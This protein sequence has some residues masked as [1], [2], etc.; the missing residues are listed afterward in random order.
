MESRA[1]R[2]WG[3][4]WVGLCVALAVHVLD[5]AMTDFLSIWNPLVESLRDRSPWLPLP[6][7]EFGAWIGGLISGVVVLF[8]LSP[9]VF[10]GARWMRPFSYL[11]AVVMLA[12]GIGHIAGSLY[13]GRPAPGVYSSPLLL[14]AA[15]FLLL[16]TG[17]HRESTRGDG[18]P[19]ARM[20]DEAA[21]A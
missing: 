10:A 15:G 20:P 5:E 7:F 16:A 13:L 1:R 6:T 2:R 4:A 12:N 3:L 8:L 11:F 19:G 21:G 14:A 9:F 18:R 17:R